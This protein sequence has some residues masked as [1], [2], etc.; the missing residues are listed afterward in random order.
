M[1]QRLNILD[2]HDEFVIGTWNCCQTEEQNDPS[3]GEYSVQKLACCM[4]KFRT[5]QFSMYCIGKR[6]SPFVVCLRR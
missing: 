2:T 6:A 4:N 3:H 1:K 5:S